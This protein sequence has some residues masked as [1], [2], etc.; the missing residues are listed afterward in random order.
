MSDLVLQKE[1]IVRLKEDLQVL[2]SP[3][4]VKV[5]FDNLWKRLEFAL[6]IEDMASVAAQ[7]FFSMTLYTGAWANAID[8]YWYDPF[9]GDHYESKEDAPQ[10]AQLRVQWREVKRWETQEQFVQY[11]RTFRPRATL[12]FRHRLL[13]QK[14]TL[15]KHA[16]ASF[17]NDIPIEVFFDLAKGVVTAPA[18]TDI[19]VSNVVDVATGTDDIRVVDQASVNRMLANNVLPDDDPGY[20][21]QVAQ[22][23]LE[24]IEEMEEIAKTSRVSEAKKQVLSDILKRPS[25]SVRLLS[26]EEGDYIEIVATAP[27]DDDGSIHPSERYRMVFVNDS[28]EVVGYSDLSPVMKSAVL[29]RFRFLHS[30]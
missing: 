5:D 29:T 20:K 17:G 9:T 10:D 24:R 15:W 22:V 25:V 16:N 21:R 8:R 18:I 11:A 2:L 28:G 23:L 3:L 30:N 13:M 7:V 1:R 6:A 12:W 14:V 4:S 27:S 26:P 19:I